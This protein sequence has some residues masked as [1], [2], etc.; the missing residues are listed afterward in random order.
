MRF[1]AI[2]SLNLSPEFVQ[3]KVPISFPLI[4]ENKYYGCFAIFLNPTQQPTSSE[5]IQANCS[6]VENTLAC[7]LQLE[8]LKPT[9]NSIKQASATANIITSYESLT[10]YNQNENVIDFSNTNSNAQSAENSNDVRD[11][12]EESENVMELSDSE[13]AES[14]NVLNLISGKSVSEN[15][16]S[17]SLSAN[18][19][20][21]EIY[22]GILS[23]I[24]ADMN[25]DKNNSG[26]ET[27][28]LT[29]QP[30]E[31]RAS[32]SAPSSSSTVMQPSHDSQNEDSQNENNQSQDV[33]METGLAFETGEQPADLSQKSE[34][35]FDFTQHIKSELDQ[36]LPA[37]TDNS[38]NLDSSLSYILQPD[39]MYKCSQCDKSFSNKNSIWQHKKTI[40]ENQRFHCHI[41]S[42]KFTRKAMLDA[43]L[44]KC[45]TTIGLNYNSYR[46][47]CPDLDITLPIDGSKPLNL[48]TTNATEN[49]SERKPL[50]RPLKTSPKQNGC[51]AKEPK[52]RNHLCEFCFK[53]FRSQRASVIHADLCKLNPN[54]KTQSPDSGEPNEPF[55]LSLKTNKY[56]DSLL[57]EVP[58]S[59]QDFG[60]NPVLAAPSSFVS[61]GFMNPSALYPNY[62]NFSNIYPA[63]PKNAPASPKIENTMTAAEQAQNAIDT[64]ANSIYAKANPFLLAANLL[65]NYKT[66]AGTLTQ[67][68][69][70]DPLTQ[71]P[72][73][74]SEDTPGDGWVKQEL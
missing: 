62:G 23:Q 37:Q 25:G 67:Q 32:T 74:D 50:G 57:K 43:H 7:T 27:K 56:A 39:G 4:K 69:S 21:E 2:V 34:P 3:Q 30:S 36:K 18:S 45:T 6:L 54:P 11:E 38:Q 42:R 31:N 71:F 40:H 5:A 72:K 10:D 61:S 70:L 55:N 16:P 26:T 52:P 64:F 53:R 60:P 20:T 59:S 14:E 41:C 28:T 49:Q 48:C 63:F 58:C 1:E 33:T 15:I 68:P 19:T 35:K 9:H 46:Q 24:V 51:V 65:A 12:N 29:P 66:A 44:I 73:P 47:S 22:N 17:E 13:R 8:Y